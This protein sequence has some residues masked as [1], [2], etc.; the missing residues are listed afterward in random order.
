MT[1]SS[2]KGHLSQ[3][4]AIRV[5]KPGEQFRTYKLDES[6]RLNPDDIPRNP[7]RVLSDKTRPHVKEEV[8]EE[9]IRWTGQSSEDPFDTIDLPIRSW[10]QPNEIDDPF[11]DRIQPFQYVD[12]DSF[13]LW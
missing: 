5:T 11:V 6:G 7:R 8:S 3:W 12:N 10:D 13:V 9:K 4:T 2:R 1:S